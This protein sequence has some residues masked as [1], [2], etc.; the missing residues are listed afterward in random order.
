MKGRLKTLK[1]KNL[2]SLRDVTIDFGEQL[3]VL[4]GP[5][6]GGKSN[7][8]KTL[9]IIKKIL[10]KSRPFLS[11]I[12]I[13]LS[14]IIFGKT[15]GSA[16]ITLESMI[17][18][19]IILHET[20]LENNK[21]TWRVTVPPL[22]NQVVDFLLN[23]GFYSF[24]PQSMLS[25]VEIEETSRLSRDGSNLAGLL[26]YLKLT[27]YKLFHIIEERLRDYVPEVE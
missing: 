24:I 14:D 25:E 4:V 1:V 19:H 16:Q 3:T 13:N 9:E 7:I 26:A 10:T 15:Q 23:M 22:Q 12:G 18:D 20:L 27:D 11:E 6:A 2:L 5:N 8:I 21:A 17:N